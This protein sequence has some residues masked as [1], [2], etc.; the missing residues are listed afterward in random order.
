MGSQ[1]SGHGGDEA[2]QPGTVDGV[3]AVILR[4]DRFLV[5]RR[6]QFVRAPGTYCFP[7]GGIQPGEDQESAIVRELR[8]EL[9]V[10]V[11]PLRRL[12]TSVTPWGVALAWWHVD[13]SESEIIEPNQQEVESVHWLSAEEMLA[14]PELLESNRAFLAA[15]R[16]WRAVGR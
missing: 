9:N 8:E 11:Q 3:V 14:L 2:A 13:L 15:S 10:A 16:N 12:W 4:T 6:S 7:G 5:I 1:M